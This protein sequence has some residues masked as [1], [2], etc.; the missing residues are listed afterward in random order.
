MNV[1][2]TRP[3][4]VEKHYEIPVHV[5]ARTL[6]ELPD[7]PSQINDDGVPEGKA[8]R[9]GAGKVD[10]TPDGPVTM[11]G[12]K[13]RTSTGVHDR[14]HV[15]ALILD[16][17]DEKLAIVSWDRL[18]AIDFEEIA[19]ARKRV[20]ECTGVPESNILLSMTHT[21]SGCEADFPAASAEA[22]AMAAANMKDARIGVGSKMIYGIGSNRRMP[23]GVGLW[24]ANQPNPDAVMDNQCGVIRIEDYDRNI[25]AVLANY[26][27]HPSVLE[28][29]NTLLSGDYAG[30]GTQEMEKRLGGG[31]VA[32]FL[33]GCAGD[34]GTHTFRTGRTTT[35]A[36]KLGNRLADAVMDILSH[37]DVSSWQRLAGA[38]R[39]IDLPIK[40][41]DKDVP[42]LPPAVEGVRTSP[43]EIQALVIGDAVILVLGSMEPYVEIGLTVKDASPF[44]QTF[45]L[46]YSNGPW[47]GYLP[48]PHGYAIKD[49]DAEGE[50][51]THYS[52]DAPH[53][54]AA[55]MLKLAEEMKA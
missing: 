19:E 27:S 18:H 39:M 3:Y 28:G 1:S 48:S 26:S 41:F 4:S 14:L 49:L 37:I 20:S 13:P 7:R 52:A 45:V 53:V 33:Q 54:L 12:F 15:R 31:A 42:T 51:S 30:I 40:E 25:I 44:R 35:E 9:A 5:E 50:R 6:P 8:L 46:G 38:K 34:T 17:G 55:E 2:E 23:D 29:G 32:M 43:D 47:L 10:I 24:Q 22:A 36:E 11:R 21:H 16:N